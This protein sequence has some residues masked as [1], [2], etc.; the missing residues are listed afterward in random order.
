M[1]TF[2]MCRC[3]W[4]EACVKNTEQEI[5]LMS[6]L[7]RNIGG[8]RLHPNGVHCYKVIMAINTANTKA[9]TPGAAVT[10]LLLVTILVQT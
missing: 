9:A 7:I 2:S 5:R 6:Q 1:Y 10:P 4:D 3:M 8:Y